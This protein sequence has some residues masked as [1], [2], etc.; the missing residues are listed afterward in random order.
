MKAVAIQK[1]VNVIKMD[2]WT[3]PVDFRYQ[4]ETSEFKIECDRVAAHKRGQVYTPKPWESLPYLAKDDLGTVQVRGF[5]HDRVAQN[6]DGSFS[7]PAS[8]STEEIIGRLGKA[9]KAHSKKCRATEISHHRL[10]FSVSSEFH[11]GLVQAGRNPD[12]VLKGIIERSMRS[13]QEKFHAGDSVSYSYGLHHDTDNLHAHIFVHPRTREGSFVGLSGKPTKHQHHA[14]AHKDQLGFLRENVRRRVSQ[15]L[16]ELSHPKEA[17][18]LKN[19]LHSDRA[20]FVP[21]HS[22]TARSKNDFRPRRPDDFQLERH[23]AAVVALDRQIMAKR[24]ALHEASGG[25]HLAMVFH[26]RQPKWLR[27]MK[28]A[29]TATLFRELRE[30]QQRRYRKISEYRAARRRVI[31]GPFSTRTVPPRRK[32]K[33]PITPIKPSPPKPTL[34]RAKPIKPSSSRRGI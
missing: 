32:S 13:F 17:S 28:K 15:V 30:L 9:W 31:P 2:S 21:R 10:V 18:H 3:S 33:T 8:L 25:R 5:L 23:R 20:Y 6:V 22:H 27:L 26:F 29:Q 1:A 34:V 16:K 24:A 14:S 4:D 12:S 19:N 11:D 7:H